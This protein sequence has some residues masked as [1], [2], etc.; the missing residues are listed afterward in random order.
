M[1]MSAEKAQKYAKKPAV[2]CCRFEQ[3]TVVSPDVLEDPSI[4]DDLV[5]SN[6]L[7]LGEDSLTIEEVLG[8]TLTE[9]LDALTPITASVLDGVKAVEKEVKEETKEE[10]TTETVAPAMTQAVANNGVL[11]IHIGEGKDINIELPLTAP[12]QQGGQVVPVATLPAAI[13]EVCCEPV[14]REMRKLEKKYFTIDKVV[15]GEET[16]VDGTTLTL[17]EDVVNQR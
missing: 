5:D 9:T 1:A 11:K 14:V 6:L 15:F 13:E 7:V 2:T 17:R 8:A 12:A 3:G 10:V 4:F 16:K